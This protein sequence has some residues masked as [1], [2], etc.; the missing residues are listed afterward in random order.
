M[1]G[2]LFVMTGLHSGNGLYYAL[3]SV[4]YSAIALLS[5][6]TDYFEWLSQIRDAF[7][8][9][10]PVEHAD[11]FNGAGTYVLDEQNQV[12]AIIYQTPAAAVR[13]STAFNSEQDEDFLIF[14]AITILRS[15]WV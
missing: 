3:F 13:I 15:H 8:R 5:N 7:K 14:F 10:K 6:I 12:R 4:I 2:V 11:Q 1:L 9:R